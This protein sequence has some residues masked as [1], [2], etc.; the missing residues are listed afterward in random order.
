MARLA[1]DACYPHLG[2]L[3]RRLIDAFQR[4]MPL[5]PRPYAEMAEAL[6]VSEAEVLAALDGLRAD[7]TLSRVGPVFAP[8]RVGASTLAAMAV[9]TMRLNEIAA[10]VS[11]YPEVNHNY[12]REHRFTLWFVVT[13]HSRDRVHEV[14]ADIERRSGFE[15]LDLPLEAEYHIDLGF[16]VQWT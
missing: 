7:G 9:P 2:V 6:G 5:S 8:N 1:T 3:E 13:A 14:L 12:E 16:P 11:G 4:G 15:V 10:L